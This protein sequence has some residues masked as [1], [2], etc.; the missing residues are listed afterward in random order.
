MPG[1]LLTLNDLKRLEVLRDRRI[2][3]LR[4]A[5][6]YRERQAR[7]DLDPVDVETA[8]QQMRSAFRAWD[9][10][11]W[12]IGRIHVRASQRAREHTR[13]RPSY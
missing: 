7:T 6:Y 10:A 12:E 4:N 9:A 5:E 11:D 3:E 13:R 8:R 1:E 2:N